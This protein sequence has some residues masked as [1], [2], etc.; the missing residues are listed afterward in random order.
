MPIDP[1][2]VMISLHKDVIVAPLFRLESHDGQFF[3]DPRTPLR[4]DNNF[5][6]RVR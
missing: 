3:R 1:V 5:F 2:L 6:A 4:I